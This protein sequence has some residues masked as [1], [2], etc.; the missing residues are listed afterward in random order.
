MK[1]RICILL[2]AG[3]MLLTAS[4]CA[5]VFETEYDYEEPVTGGFGALSG[6]VTELSNYSMLKT[7]ITDMIS[8]HEESRE[9]RLTNYNGSP[10]E[11]L[12]AVCYEIKSA[13]PLG[14]YAVE[15]LSYDTNYVV[16]Y[17]MAN[18]YISYQ[19]TAEE[20]D[21]ICFARTQPEFDELL[22]GA[23]DQH[24]ESIVI[25]IYSQAV[26]EAYIRHLVRRHYFDDAVTTVLEPKVS[27][28]S[29][30]GEGA[31]RIYCIDLDYGWDGNRLQAMSAELSEVL[32]AA[33]SALTETELPQLALEAAVWLSGNCTEDGGTEYPDTAY[34]AAVEHAE[35]SQ[36]V[37]LAYRA[38]CARL[39]IP[40]TVVEGSVG[41]M[42][43]EP[44]F[45]NIIELDGDSYHVDVFAMAE[46]PAKAFLLNDDALWGTYIWDT[47]DYPACSGALNYAA[48]AGITEP[49]D[50]EEARPEQ[51]ELPP[52]PVETAAGTEDTEDILK[53]N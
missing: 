35:N 7:A 26:D 40:C 50:A 22:H 48:V 34:G 47:E 53:E 25:R 6:D 46:D 23:V 14:A 17:Y 29:W 42:G 24:L 37:A 10:S 36:G 11:D 32:D 15:S 39:E 51:G 13:N 52:D 19:R 43:A 31:N 2:L 33:A 45:W 20:I 49:T 8:R 38:L 41:A 27:V 12:A 21:S 28:S 44:H 9:F 30:P 1:N 3:L 4:G 16:S 5:S 18:I